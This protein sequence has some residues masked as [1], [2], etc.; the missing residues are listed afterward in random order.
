LLSGDADLA[1]DW[2]LQF[3][4]AMTLRNQWQRTA[5]GSVIL[6]PSELRFLGAQLRPTFANP[7]AIVDVRV[8]QASIHAIDRK[9]LAD[10]ML[11]GEG[12]VADT[13]ALPYEPF[14]E[15]LVRVVA[16][17]PYDPRRTEELMAQVG[18]AKGNDGMY[19]HAR[20]GR[21]APEVLGIGEG[22]E[23]KETTAVA[24]YFRSAGF[25]A[26][27]RLVP[28]LQMQ[29]DNELKATYPAWRSNYLLSPDKFHSANNAT[30]E[31]QWRGNNK[32]GW[33]N[34]ENDRLVDLWTQ[35]LEVNERNHLMLLAYKNISDDLPG[36]PLYYNYSV[37]AHT[38]RLRGPMG[39][40]AGTSYY[41]NLHEWQSVH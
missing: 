40:T 17:Y 9:A 36:L 16:K 37:I 19:T 5:D 4:S 3:E 1:L 27:L 34:A 31:N 33:V 13:A 38:A 32:L 22:Q 29:R 26:Q 28:A 30:P 23:G 24:A 10:G 35:S 25:D 21:F 20:E 11:D 2:A 14:Y 39:A 15:D 12:I 18:Y 41:P 8:R 7:S 6:T